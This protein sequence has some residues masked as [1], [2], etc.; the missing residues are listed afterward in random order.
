[1]INMVYRQTLEIKNIWFKVI[2]TM[3]LSIIFMGFSFFNIF[4]VVPIQVSAVLIWAVSICFLTFYIGYLIRYHSEKWFYQSDQI[5]LCRLFH[6]KVKVN[7]SDIKELVIG[8]SYIYSRY[9]RIYL[10]TA[11]IENGEKTKIKCPWVSILMTPKIENLNE[12][13]EYDVLIEARKNQALGFSMYD[14]ERMETLL[15]K[16]TGKIYISDSIN[17]SAKPLISEL[18]DYCNGADLKYIN[19]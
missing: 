14:M 10:N 16:F 11:Y 1:M 7:I 3:I 2:V 15:K 6:K 5:V 12:A 4:P 13:K 9:G 19:F 8:E 18:K 17:G